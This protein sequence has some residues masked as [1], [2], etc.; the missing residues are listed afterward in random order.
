MFRGFTSKT[1]GGVGNLAEDDCASTT[2]SSD[3]GESPCQSQVDAYPFGGSF[4][5]SLGLPDLSN[6]YPYPR[7]YGLSNESPLFLA[8][9]PHTTAPQDAEEP[10]LVSLADQFYPPSVSEVFSFEYDFSVFSA[11]NAVHFATPKPFI[12]CSVRELFSAVIA[13]GGFHVVSARPKGWDLLYQVIMS[14]GFAKMLRAEQQWRPEDATRERCATT[15][16]NLSCSNRGV[17][18]LALA[19]D[20]VA[21]RMERGTTD[22]LLEPEC[23]SDSHNRFLHGSVPTLEHV[24]LRLRSFYMGAL[25]SYESPLVYEAC[26]WNTR[27]VT[28]RTGLFVQVV[29]SKKLYIDIKPGMPVLAPQ[30]ARAS[31]SHA[32]GVFTVYLHS[33]FTPL[34]SLGDSAVHS[35]SSYRKFVTNL[36]ENSLWVEETREFLPIGDIDLSRVPQG[37]VVLDV[38][39]EKLLVFCSVRRAQAPRAAASASATGSA[40]SSTLSGSLSSPTTETNSPLFKRAGVVRGVIYGKLI[41]CDPGLM[42]MF[43]GEEVETSLHVRFKVADFAADCIVRPYSMPARKLAVRTFMYAHWV[44]ANG[45][46][47]EADIGKPLRFSSD[48]DSDSEGDSEAEGEVK[49]EAVSSD[50]P[51]DG[52]AEMSDSDICSGVSEP[53]SKSKPEDE[54][55]ILDEFI[56]FDA[57]TGQL[58]PIDAI[59]DVRKKQQYQLDP[60]TNALLESQDAVLTSVQSVAKGGGSDAS[61]TPNILV[62]ACGRILSSMP[63]PHVDCSKPLFLAQITEWS[64]QYTGILSLWVLSSSD[65]WYVLGNPHPSYVPMYRR[66][67]QRMSWEVGIFNAILDAR[68]ERSPRSRSPA[69]DADDDDQQLSVFA[70]V[71]IVVRSFGGRLEWMFDRLLLEDVRKSLA[72]FYEDGDEPFPACVSEFFTMIENPQRLIA[73]AS[74]AGVLSAIQSDAKSIH[75]AVLSRKEVLSSESRCMV[76]EHARVRTISEAIEANAASKARNPCRIPGPFDIAHPDFH[77]PQSIGSTIQQQDKQ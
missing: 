75:R 61:A 47:T 71:D 2:S 19:P 55:L 42:R 7:N 70:L 51:I 57:N 28:S 39:S 23:A 32:H 69:E 34:I 33:L 1:I 44:V 18:I 73:S 35:N 24:G 15:A 52:F 54:V 30:M 58:V 46:L 60:D 56:F 10:S 49:T 48:L 43:A 76:A 6:T 36:T 68:P 21:R 37:S 45:Y 72:K 20:D 77:R 29:G 4:S 31:W 38:E 16:R 27:S 8:Q 26:Q 74:S 40:F 64:V 13:G 25:A 65:Q 12:P 14:G 22:H 62:S 66:I 41:E 53:V 63:L 67:H 17:G 9:F 50:M 11:I 3:S 5:A 59:V